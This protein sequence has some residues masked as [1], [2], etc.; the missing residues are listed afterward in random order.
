MILRRE[1]VIIYLVLVTRS[2]STIVLSKFECFKCST[3]NIV[4][5]HVV[6]VR[7]KVNP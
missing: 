1:H 7:Q 6:S 4:F 3:I 5:N 2:L